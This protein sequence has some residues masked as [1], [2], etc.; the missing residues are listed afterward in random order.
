MAAFAEASARPRWYFENR[1]KPSF[2]P[3]EL[4]K[5]KN[6]TIIQAERQELFYVL[7]CFSHL[8]GAT[9]GQRASKTFIPMKLN[10]S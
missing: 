1:I 2:A 8:L 10:E 9:E 6:V 3:T 7:L 5:G 4:W